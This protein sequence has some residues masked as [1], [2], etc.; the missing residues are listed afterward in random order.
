[1][2]SLCG[3]HRLIWDNTLHTCIKPPFTEQ[4][5][6]L[7]VIKVTLACPLYTAVF[8][9]IQGCDFSAD[10]RISADRVVPGVIAE[11]RVNSGKKCWWRGGYDRSADVFHKGPKYPRPAKSL[12]ILHWWILPYHFWNKRC[13]WLPFTNLPIKI[14][15]WK[16]AWYFLLIC[17]QI[18]P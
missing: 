9:S 4:G 6:Y 16:W 8:L 17:L 13:H 1:M 3:L 2:I 12:R 15:L 7:F 11:I 5:S 18:A 14:G 10:P